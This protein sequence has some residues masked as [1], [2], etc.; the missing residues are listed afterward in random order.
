MILQVQTFS[1]CLN[2]FLC[3]LIY[4]RAANGALNQV[5]CT[6]LKVAVLIH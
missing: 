4:D 3:E 6:V 2:M 5:S 1:R